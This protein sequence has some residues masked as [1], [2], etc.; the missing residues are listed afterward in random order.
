MKMMKYFSASLMAL[1]ILV[2]VMQTTAAPVKTKTLKMKVEFTCANCQAKIQTGLTKTDGVESAVADLKTK[3][4]TITYDP[5]K[6]DKDKL[7][8]VVE[9][10]GYRTEFTAKDAPLSHE[11]TDK[12]EDCSKKCDGMKK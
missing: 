2:N 3:V 9:G 8:K 5:A 10:L 4:V 7:V 11:C 6:T 12:K 1:F